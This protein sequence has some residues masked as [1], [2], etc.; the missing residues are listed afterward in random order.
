LFVPRCKK[1]EMVN[2]SIFPLWACGTSSQAPCVAVDP[3][4]CRELLLV[5]NCNLRCT[6]VINRVQLNA[7]LVEETNMQLCLEWMKV[8]REK[9]GT[10]ESLRLGWVWWREDQ[11]DD[12]KSTLANWTWLAL[13]RITSYCQ[14]PLMFVSAVRWVN[15]WAR[16]TP[17]KK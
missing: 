14:S 5:D 4:E 15:F 16:T 3:N 7:W 10:V 17:R 1:L 8:P 13:T 2:S 6:V 9:L 12:P 11:T